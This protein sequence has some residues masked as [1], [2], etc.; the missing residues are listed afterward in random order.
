MPAQF[1]IPVPSVPQT[2]GAGVNVAALAPILTVLSFEDPSSVVQ[3]QESYD[4]GATFQNLAAGLFTGAGV[5]VVEVEGQQIRAFLVSGAG[6]GNLQA[7]PQGGG[8]AAVGNIAVPAGSGPSPFL[9]ISG[10]PPNLVL[11]LNTVA[12]PQPSTVE[13]AFDGANFAQLGNITPGLS[14][15]IV[16]GTNQ[17][18]LNRRGF[19]GVAGNLKVAGVPAKTA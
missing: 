16:A 18:R 2:G 3:L 1:N 8:V 5:A 7:A 15:P 19:G 11:Q 6:G 17:L 12:D 10:Q 14:V 13:V 9:D 4:G